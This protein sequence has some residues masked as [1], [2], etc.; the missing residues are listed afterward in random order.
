MRILVVDDSRTITTVFGARLVEIGH[1]VDIADA[2]RFA[3]EVAKEVGTGLCR[4][5]DQTEFERLVALYGDMRRL[6]GTVR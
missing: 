2:V 1:E 4:F 3:I 5:H 6:Q